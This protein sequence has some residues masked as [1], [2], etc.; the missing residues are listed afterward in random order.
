MPSEARV[1]AE[2]SSP[3]CSRAAAVWCM[4]VVLVG[5]LL[6][7]GVV[8]THSSELSLDRDAYLGI[9]R[10]IQ[11]GRG[12]S[13][14]GSVH[15]TAYRPPLYPLLLAPVA[16][17]DQAWLRGG[18][19][20]LLGTAAVALTWRTARRWGLGPGLAAVA[21]GLIAI[22]PLLLL[23]TPQV[24]TETPAVLLAAAALS[25]LGGPSETW[26]LRRQLA[27][28]I[29]LGLAS[30][31][32]P[33]FFAWTGLLAIWFALRGFAA[34]TGP[35]PDRARRLPWFVLVAFVLTVA[36]WPIRNQLR[37]G[38]PILTTTHGGYTLL[39][40]NNE[41]YYD[42]VIR[43]G[44]GGQWSGPQLAQW[45]RA[46]AAAMEERKITGELAQDRWMKEQ[47]KIWIA[48]HPREFRE[49][50]AERLAAFWRLGPAAVPGEPVSMAAQGVKL[51]YAAEWLL[52]LWGLAVAIGRR[53]AD[54]V[55]LVLLAVV[56]TATHALYFSNARMRA[57]LMP[58]IAL[59][60]A[61]GLSRRASLQPATAT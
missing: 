27:L 48:A 33:T 21:A 12:Y 39:L 20:I 58:A 34:G 54:V 23:Y 38:A 35:W 31:C 52:A 17:A 16:G 56:F 14:P 46:L 13:S 1:P 4:A 29:T 3:G 18:L 45:Q 28:G 51:L 57:P 24:M 37:L 47:A 44:T 22:D 15:P 55:P 60:A 36:P 43:A 19:Q 2:T 5:L 10:G 42:E 11:E 30:L 32:R 61:A 7:I 8:V 6:R 50:V 59:L 41:R 9:A 53:R 40:S 26:L 49:C 25:L